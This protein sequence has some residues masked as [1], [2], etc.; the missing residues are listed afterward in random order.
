MR[1]CAMTCYLRHLKDILAEAGIEVTSSN[2]KQLDVAVHQFVKVAH[3]DCP[4][5]WNRLKSDFLSDTD[6]RNEL[7]DHLRRS[8]RN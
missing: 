8:I 1:C 2:R 6:K 5:T 3:K 4:A 7:V